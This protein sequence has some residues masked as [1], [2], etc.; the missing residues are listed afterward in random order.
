MDY[1]KQMVFAGH[2]MRSG[3]D[4]ANRGTT[5][6]KLVRTVTKEVGKIGMPAGKLSDFQ[7]WIGITPGIFCGER[8]S[9]IMIE[10]RVIQLFAFSYGCAVVS[11]GRGSETEPRL[12][13]QRRIPGLPLE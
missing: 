12:S 8:G 5:K 6:H 7:R 1:R 11:S 10:C 3:R 2:V 4:W 9:Q 13:G